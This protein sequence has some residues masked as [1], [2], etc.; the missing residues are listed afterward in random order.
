[1]KKTRYGRK[2]RRADLIFV[3][4]M[5]F[6]PIVQFLIMW[7][8]VNFNSILLA[9]KQ[10]D[11]NF[12]Y[13]YSLANFE[14]VI[15]ELQHN[16]GVQDS[17]NTSV[18]FWIFTSLLTLP[19]SLL[20]SYYLYKRYK[21]HNVL[22]TAY[23][24]PSIMA[25]IVTVT[26]FY[27]LVDRGYPFLAEKLTGESKL[28]LLVNQETQFGTLIFYNVFYSLA[29]G[30]LYMSSAMS[31]VDEGLS[32]AAQIDGATPLQ[33][34]FHV[35]LP[36]IYPILSV[37]FVSTIPSMF[38]NDYGLFAFFKTV[39]SSVISVMGSYF[40]VGLTT[41]GEAGYPYFAAFG[42]VLSVIAGI[43][44]FSIKAVVNRMD[45]FRDED[46]SIAQAKRAK[47]E[48]RKARREKRA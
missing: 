21:L 25:G 34:F 17:M 7:I 12:D 46:G 22:K 9:F 45:P 18:I 15:D 32:E 24:I 39:G 5:L 48:R 41:Q 47:R 1:M 19:V 2:K 29:Q 6:L 28:G 31:G 16:A 23:F 27:I 35:I 26:S 3:T 20:I 11:I 43:L 37:Y 14:R 4:V 13:T 42:L 30:F 40:M 8:G 44:T 10:Y 38:V 36:C 33:E